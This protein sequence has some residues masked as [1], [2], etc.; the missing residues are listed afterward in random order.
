MD[1]KEFDGEL[2][3]INLGMLRKTLEDN[4]SNATKLSTISTNDFP[5][6]PRNF[7]DPHLLSSFYLSICYTVVKEA[8]RSKYHTKCLK[9]SDE[10]A[11]VGLL[12]VDE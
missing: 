1:Q 7:F 4:I 2:G 9:D 11:H 10:T 5:K 12:D 8:L 3:A 6:D